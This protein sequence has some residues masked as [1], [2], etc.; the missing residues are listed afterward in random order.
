MSGQAVSEWLTQLNAWGLT[1]MPWL[2]REILAGRCHSGQFAADTQSVVLDQAPPAGLLTPVQARQCVVVLGL[3]G[4]SLGRH[5]QEED[6][7]HRVTPQQAFAPLRAPRAN[8]AFVDYFSS[9]A[10]RTGT[11][12]ASRDTYAGLIRWNLPPCEVWW[13]G[14]RLAHLDSA[15]DDEG[16]RTYTG[17]PDEE[18][19]FGLLKACET[20]ERSV[21]T[22]LEPIVFAEVEV[23]SA[24]ARTALR[25]AKRLVDYL[26]H[27]NQEFAIRQDDGIGIDYFMDVFR[28]FAIHWTPGDIPPSGALDVESLARDLLLGLTVPDYAGHLRS[29]YPVLLEEERTRLSALSERPSLPDLALDAAGV[30]PVQL[31]GLPEARQKDLLGAHPVLGDLYA[32]LTAQARAGGV[33]LRMTKKFLFNPQRTRDDTGRGDHGVVSNRRGTTG[34]DEGHLQG[35]T[36]ARQHHQLAPLRAGVHALLESPTTSTTT[37]TTEATLRPV[38]RPS[39]P[40]DD[41][42]GPTVRFVGHDLPDLGL[43]SR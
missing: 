1:R 17:T 29:L 4:A 34:L 3:A 6:A 23:E 14:V 43:P 8:L 21:N 39:R 12:H 18:R 27:V 37:S 42:A 20:I 13:D 2:N 36:R 16:V 31:E 5:Y 9:V 26:R 32:L 33:H 22:L 10:R 11:G 7:R 38:P 28:Q 24:R 19:F 15:F 30:S 41:R 25:Q 35:L 40:G